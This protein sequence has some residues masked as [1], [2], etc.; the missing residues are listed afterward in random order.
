MHTDQRP[1]AIFLM[2]PTASGKTA[3]ALHLAERFPVDLISV[4]SALVYRGLDI[5][6]AKPDVATLARHPHRL[7]DIREPA[8][9]YSAAEFRTDALREMAAITSA[10]R[11]PLL[12]GGTGLYFRALQYGLSDL[13]EADPALRARLA[14]EA[15]AIGWPA[16]HARLHELD[17]AAAARIRPGDAQRIQ[18]AL[19]VIALSGR[20]LSEQ[21]GALAQR[22]GYR[23][24][25]LAL[26]PA[27]R[28][29]LHA[30]IAAR[31]DAMLAQGFVAEVQRLRA[32]GD[33]HADLPAIRAVGYRQAWQQI[34][35]EFDARELRDRGIF[36]TRQ[37]AKRQLTW[38]RA[39][40]D[41]RWLDPL[42][43]RHASTAES[44]VEDFLARP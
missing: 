41:A 5:G 22:F 21:Q 33:L 23:I 11:I 19:E 20:P 3:L 17:P 37:L 44:A 14:D 35:G 27:D 36:A 15:R 32:R 1:R 40:L 13:P 6:S 30:R 16:L 28:A 34:D 18:R 43:G 26:V 2:G 24:L 4:D 39:E 31:F 7:I 29:V 8:Q 38:L 12:V 25:K 42:D 9:P 10:G